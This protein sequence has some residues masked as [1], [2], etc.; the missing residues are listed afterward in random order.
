MDTGLSDYDFL[1]DSHRL[2]GQR[3]NRGRR[4]IS[5][6]QRSLRPILVRT[7]RDTLRDRTEDDQIYENT[8]VC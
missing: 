2:I 7:T 5:F 8:G 6:H 4:M 1:E 3:E